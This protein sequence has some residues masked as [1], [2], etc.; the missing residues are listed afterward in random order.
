MLVLRALRKLSLKKFADSCFVSTDSLAGLEWIPD[1]DSFLDNPP[2][3]TTEI[4]THPETAEEFEK[5]K[6]YF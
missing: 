2:E 1:I 3:G 5:I 4:V 6:K